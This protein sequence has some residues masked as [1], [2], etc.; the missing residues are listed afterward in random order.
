MLIVKPAFRN[1]IGAGLQTWLNEIVLSIAVMDIVWSHGFIIGMDEQIM[2]EL[3]ET[4]Y[5]EGQYWTPFYGPYDPFTED[6]SH[7]PVSAT[8]ADLAARGEAAPVLI[9]SGALLSDGRSHPVLLKG[10]DPDQ[11]IVN[12]LAHVL[13]DR[14]PPVIP[15]LI[16]VRMAGKIKLKAGDFV[17]VQW[18][19]VHGAFDAED[20]K[21]VH[22]MCINV[23]T[24]DSGVVWLPLEKMR[25]M[26]AAPEDA[27]F[28]ILGRDVE[29]T[30]Q[31]GETWIFRVLDYLLK[32]LKEIIRAKSASSAIFYTLLLSIALLAIALPN[33]L[34]PSYDPGLI[35]GTTLILFVTMTLVRDWPT[36]K[37]AKRKPTDAPWG[38]MRGSRP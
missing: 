30:S 17:T 18:R 10:L 28:V 16:G 7:A 29:N 31:R 33:T 27:S 14:A 23:P 2:T 38:V 5:G 20:I 8:L 22:I 3:I 12:T 1:M 36:R 37:I 34:Y 35:A 25:E 9:A 15:A 19:N 26:L 24:A 6:F 13:K 4:K 11:K 32:D 21:I